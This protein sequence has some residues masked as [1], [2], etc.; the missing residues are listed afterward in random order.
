MSNLSERRKGESRRAVEQ[1]SQ[2]NEGDGGASENKPQHTSARESDPTRSAVAPLKEVKD[3][4]SPA[5]TMPTVPQDE[6]IRRR[7][8]AGENAVDH[9]EV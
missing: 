6:Q 2:L 9:P 7:G 1:N 5:Q 8:D 3:Q 4:A